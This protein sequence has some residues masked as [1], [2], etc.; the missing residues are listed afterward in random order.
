MAGGLRLHPLIMGLPA[1]VALAWVGWYSF[2]REWV[3]VRRGLR[4]IA[5]GVITAG[6]A[7]AASIYLALGAID[8]KPSLG[9]ELLTLLLAVCAFV[10][11]YSMAAVL[12]W[13]MIHHDRY[14]EDASGINDQET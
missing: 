3:L 7:L 1:V 2:R 12:A 6:V 11:Y 14:C 9:H 5:Y 8:G 4:T 13:M 10:A